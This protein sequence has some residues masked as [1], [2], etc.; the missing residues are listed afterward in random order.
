MRFQGGEKVGD[1]TLLKLVGT[2]HFKRGA[3]VVWLC[4]CQ[5]GREVQRDRQ[6]LIR[7]K[8][9]GCGECRTLGT[10]P[11]GKWKHPL[12]K[13]WRHMISRCT[14]QGNKSYADYGERGITICPRWIE[15]E[16]GLTGLECFAADMGERPS[17]MTL[18][19]KD[20]NRGYEPDNCV[21]ANRTVQS[22]NRRNVRLISFQGES[23]PITV[24]AER[25]GIPYFTL[26]AR[27]KKWPVERALTEPVAK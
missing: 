8:R 22:R 14:E 7:S 20:V 25:T 21:W 9:P 23:L 2:K 27:L 17:G 4:R 16:D 5:C 11:A 3:A 12:Y 1:L 24:W 13:C 10:A 19:R 26:F 6:T 15:G 18:E